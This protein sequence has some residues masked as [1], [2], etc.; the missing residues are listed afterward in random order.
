MA[1]VAA[2]RSARDAIVL[3]RV[4]RREVKMS[5]VPSGAVVLPSHTLHSS[6]RVRKSYAGRGSM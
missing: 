5:S 3:S 6:K 2:R 4:V 1:G